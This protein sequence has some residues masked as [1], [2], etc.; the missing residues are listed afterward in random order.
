MELT[1]FLH[2]GTSSQNLKDHQKVF[3]WA[4]SK[5]GAASLVT[6]L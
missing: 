1:D 4:M 3:R 2:A 5:M 6:G